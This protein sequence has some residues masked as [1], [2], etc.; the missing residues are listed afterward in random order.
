MALLKTVSIAF[1][2]IYFVTIPFHPYTGSAVVKGLSIAT[3]AVL[4]WISSVRL[5]SVALAVSAVGDVLLD[6][7][8]AHLF[9][10]GL[11]AFLAAHVVY[12]VLFV[13]WR[14][15][16]VRISGS[17][18]AVLV[19]IL[20]YAVGVSIWLA[21][22]L[23]SMIVPVVI[24]ICVITAMV[25]ASIF[26]RLPILV[27]LGAVL[28]LASDSMLAIARFKGTFILRDYL[29]WATYYLAQYLMASG[30]STTR[31]SRADE[32]VRPTLEPRT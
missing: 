26:A 19:V 3:L 6:L 24:Y 9:V 29:V 4:A 14:P 10:A 30:V 12:T 25:T 13:S 32:G 1:S 2:A 5:L 15:R 20:V 21:P 8:P 11:C 18:F 31:G 23:G 22:S 17:R 16:P 28:F 7:D 27:P